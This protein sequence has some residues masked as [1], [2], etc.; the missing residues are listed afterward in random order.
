MDEEDALLSQILGTSSY[1]Y[2]SSISAKKT[3]AGHEPPKKI[4][5]RGKRDEATL[6]RAIMPSSK[7]N[8]DILDDLIAKHKEDEEYSEKLAS[9][10]QEISAKQD[11]DLASKVSKTKRLSTL[12]LADTDDLHQETSFMLVYF[13]PVHV[14]VVQP[15][16]KHHT[17]TSPS[18][19]QSAPRLPNT[20][21]AT[22]NTTENQETFN[23]LCSQPNAIL[24]MPLIRSYLKNRVCPPNVAE[25]LLDIVCGSPNQEI[26][27]ESYTTLLS[28]L[29]TPPTGWPALI[30]KNSPSSSSSGHNSNR[31]AFPNEFNFFSIFEARLNS[32]FG[33]GVAPALIKQDTVESILMERSKFSLMAKKASRYGADA[34]VHQLEEEAN[35]DTDELASATL[36][37][38]QLK[39][40]SSHSSALF[41][42]YNFGLFMNFLAAC[43]RT[44]VVCDGLD[45]QQMV[46]VL[47]SL[48]RII[49]DPNCQNLHA[50]VQLAILE[51]YGFLVRSIGIED[52]PLL[53]N[54]IAEALWNV[55]P[56][57][58][59]DFHTSI[60]MWLH[61]TPCSKSV[62]ISIR[63]ALAFA[64]LEKQLEEMAT[65]SDD[66]ISRVTTPT[67]A[68]GI[69][70]PP[71]GNHLITIQQVTDLVNSCRFPK[72]PT[73]RN[74]KLY[75]SWSLLVDIALTCFTALELLD[76]K[77][78]LTSWDIAF[79]GWMKQAKEKGEYDL[80]MTKFK[81][82]ATHSFTKIRVISNSVNAPTR[83]TMISFLATGSMAPSK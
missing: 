32:Y 76:I 28:L 31:N 58:R 27:L 57:P 79:N 63:A 44:G 21:S 52:L 45:R 6:A 11:G 2:K 48:Y 70:Q 29:P 47:I 73:K 8:G 72:D 56:A 64:M 43:A 61:H 23:R 16:L 10:V 51:W 41:R 71:L 3:A 42:T 77:R 25:W 17:I 81:D 65:S 69:K 15:Q 68:A 30:C 37:A 9:I 62:M 74:W 46:Q 13:A 18:S 14:P 26:A 33:A 82:L 7:T 4:S 66:E 5:K 67:P 55:L 12:D 34:L 40:Q 38:V 80:Q 19:S 49:L 20:M 83:S 24:K 36:A 39:I 1:P 50:D 35:A 53:V 60:F 59:N 78:N 75:S 22:E 54:Q